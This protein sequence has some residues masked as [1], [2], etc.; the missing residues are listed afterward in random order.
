MT[1][2]SKSHSW[3]FVGSW[4]MLRQT[5]LNASSAVKRGLKGASTS[6]RTPVPESTPETATA[7]EQPPHW[8][9]KPIRRPGRE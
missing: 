6:A 3:S 5:G 8:W 4:F 9:E 2:F 7:T 1:G